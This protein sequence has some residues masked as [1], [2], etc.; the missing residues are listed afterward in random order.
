MPVGEDDD[1]DEDIVMWTR[2]FEDV[3]REMLRDP[4][5]DYV[6]QRAGCLL[7]YDPKPVPNLYITP[8]KTR[9]FRCRVWM[10]PCFL[11]GNSCNTIPYSRRR[12][13]NVDMGIRADTAVD[14]GKG[15]LLYETNIWMW[16]FGRVV[17]RSIGVAKAQLLRARAQTVRNK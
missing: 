15:S 6:T 16:R 8:V 5:L 14:N 9:N 12:H 2:V 13:N 7:M 4:R 17:P 3:V 11:D 1:G 10:T